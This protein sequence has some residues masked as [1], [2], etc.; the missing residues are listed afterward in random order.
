LIYSPSF[1]RTSAFCYAVSPQILL[2]TAHWRRQVFSAKG[3]S[4]ITT[5]SKAFTSMQLS[6]DAFLTPMETP[7][8]AMQRT[9]TRPVFTFEIIKPFS[10]RATPLSVAVAHLVLVG[11]QPDQ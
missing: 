9:A 1:F 4:D 11:Q 5:L 7:N 10:L 3:Y 8:Q 2:R 6:M